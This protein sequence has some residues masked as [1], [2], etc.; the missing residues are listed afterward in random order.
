MKNEEFPL[1]VKAGGVCVKIYNVSTS[2]RQRY[3]VA[4]HDAGGRRL[5]QFA[6]LADARREAKEIAETLNDG[7][8]G[9][10]ELSGADRDAYLAA[11]RQLRPLDISL[12]TAIAEYVD[13][14]KWNVPLGQAA[15]SYAETHNA[16]LPD[17][18]YRYK[19]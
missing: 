12:A 15:K 17:T 16:R 10:L 14:K 5:R 1:E 11:V 9:A 7:R 8:G 4:Y 18:V 3:T 19:E 13:A 2:E 6:D